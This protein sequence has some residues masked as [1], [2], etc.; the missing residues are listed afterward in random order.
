MTGT[1]KFS[2]SVLSSVGD[3]NTYLQLICPCQQKHTSHTQDT[4]THTHTHTLQ[5]LQS[6]IIS[7]DNRHIPTLFHVK[8]DP[9]AKKTSNHFNAQMKYPMHSTERN[10]KQ[11]ISHG[12][13]MH[14]SKKTPGIT[15]RIHRRLFSPSPLLSLVPRPPSLAVVQCTRPPHRSP[16]LIP[17][18]LA[19]DSSATRKKMK[20]SFKH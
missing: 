17:A 9:D 16:S 2:H 13:G 7:G 10:R 1:L 14:C 19:L 15:T 18:Q 11:V 8:Q 6:H 4:H 5:D 12:E 3:H 20:K